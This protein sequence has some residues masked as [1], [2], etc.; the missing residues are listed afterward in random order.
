M[1]MK[2]KMMIGLAAGLFIFYAAAIPVW[3]TT[4]NLTDDSGQK[5]GGSFEYFLT[6][7]GTETATLTFDLCGY[8]TVD[9]Y[10]LGSDTT[11]IFTLK[12]NGSKVFSGSFDM[13]GGFGQ[14]TYV[15]Y[16]TPGVSFTT[17]T[18]G[19]GQGGLTQFTVTFTLLSGNNSFQFDY[20]AMQ[21]ILDESWAIQ[22]AS[23]STVPVPPAFILFGSGLAGLAA[24]RLRRKKQK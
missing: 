14:Y 2:K 10:A 5:S 17:S 9:G 23:V 12:I 11:D 13:G 6:S 22:K 16:Q 18:F 20:G 19:L 8:N 7:S 21:G 4:T 24:T 1:T 3:A 15:Y